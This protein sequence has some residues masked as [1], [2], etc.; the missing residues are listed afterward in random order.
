MVL[1]MGEGLWPCLAVFFFFLFAHF[2]TSLALSIPNE[3]SSF[4][5]SLIFLIASS[6]NV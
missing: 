1:V 2:V 4:L 6:F 3:I 5:F